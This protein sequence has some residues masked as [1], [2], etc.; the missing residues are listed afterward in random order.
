VSKNLITKIKDR[1]Q[2]A[3]GI[4]S[5]RPKI[6]PLNFAVLFNTTPTGYDTYGRRLG[7]IDTIVQA[8]INTIINIFIVA[9]LQTLYPIL[10]PVFVSLIAAAVASTY[11]VVSVPLTMVGHVCDKLG[12]TSV[13]SSIFNSIGNAWNGLL[14][15]IGWNDDTPA[16]QQGPVASTLTSPEPSVGSNSLGEQTQ[17]PSNVVQFSQQPEVPAFISPA[18][19]EENLSVE[20][21]QLLSC[22]PS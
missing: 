7:I 18:A 8:V 2:E 17:D 15:F 10:A 22:K 4:Y 1:F 12:I 14:D 6:G 3:K 16:L 9:L 20:Q 19:N 13:V 5:D 11:F 21:Q